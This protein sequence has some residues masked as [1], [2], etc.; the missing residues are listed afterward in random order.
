MGPA[1]ASM[2][3]EG[4]AA[5]VAAGLRAPLRLSREAALSRLAKQLNN[6]SAGAEGEDFRAVMCKAVMDLL[7]AAEW[8]PRLGG[9]EAAQVRVTCA[10]AM[11]W[12]P[13][14]A[15]SGSKTPRAQFPERL[16]VGAQR[17][18]SR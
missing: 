17:L 8:Q 3:A 11:P 5:E 14:T 4:L 15:C 12:M 9:L 1:C 18:P 10:P 16:P 2:A 6:N 7:S 13:S